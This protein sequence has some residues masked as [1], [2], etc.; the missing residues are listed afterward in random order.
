MTAFA[1]CFMCL[2]ENR[3]EAPAPEN[4]T[5]QHCGA[6]LAACGQRLDIGIPQR[7]AAAGGSSAPAAEAEIREVCRP[8][9]AE[10]G[11]FAAAAEAALVSSQLSGKSRRPDGGAVSGGRML[12][13][14]TVLDGRGETSQRLDR[15]A[16]AR[17][18]EGGGRA[19]AG[20]PV[21]GYSAAT[22]ATECQPEATPFDIT[23]SS[24]RTA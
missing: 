4:W 7:K 15:P 9:D 5:C 16:L 18:G 20:R 3:A 17:S 14:P 23:P 13:G 12:Q 11:G 2:R 19:L 8:L 21:P 1:I 22:T 10:D 24:R 6:S